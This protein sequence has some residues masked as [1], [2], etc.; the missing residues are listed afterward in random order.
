MRLRVPRRPSPA[1]LVACVALVAALA[2]SAAATVTALPDG[3]VGTVQLA[4][5]AVISPKIRNGAVTALDIANSTITGA[6]VRDRSLTHA[7]FK[8]GSLPPG[9][10]GE[11]G[12]Q[13]PQGPKGSPGTSGRQVVK[14]DSALSSASSKSV[15]AACPAGKKA[16]G[17][18]VEV[19]GDGRD[20]VSV[21]GSVPAGD[22]GWQARAVELLS[23]SAPWQLHVY[24]V[25]AFVA[26]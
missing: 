3:S 25:C 22:A 6:D 12:A 23:T 18:G 15:T 19:S 10:R 8:P 17:G 26:S 1:L 7:D 24:A 13:G 9:P 2:G 4:D 14:A 5:D 21:T 11:T 16:L 20:R